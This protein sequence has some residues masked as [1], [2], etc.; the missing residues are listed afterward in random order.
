MINS[1]M[2]WKLV[3]RIRYLPLSII[4]INDIKQHYLEQGGKPLA[5][6]MIKVI[7][8]EINT[9]LHNPHK[10]PPYELVPEVRRLVVANGTYLVFHRV[11]E[12]DIQVLHV[13]R[14]ERAPATEKDME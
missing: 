3:L 7:R 5:L 4:D 2:N 14:S 10:A 6:R 12:V 8:A 1:L 9:L 11:T 13:R